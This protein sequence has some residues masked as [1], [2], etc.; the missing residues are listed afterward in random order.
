LF[1]DEGFTRDTV[2]ALE[3]RGH[4]T[5]QMGFF[6]AVQVIHQTGPSE[7]LGASDPRKGGWPAGVR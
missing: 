6:S 4:T 3:A 1:L 2:R 7:L 5:A